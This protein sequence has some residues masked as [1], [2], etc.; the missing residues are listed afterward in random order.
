MEEFDGA[1]ILL[2]KHNYLELEVQPAVLHIEFDVA[3]DETKIKAQ[4]N[5][6]FK[7]AV[8]AT[9]DD[10]N[11]PNSPPVSHICDVTPSIYGNVIT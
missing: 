5:T 1:F 4:F 3:G 7:T 6:I 10:S 2:S 9:E 11:G 8:K